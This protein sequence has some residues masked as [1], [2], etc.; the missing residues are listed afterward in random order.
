LTPKV[1]KLVAD[2]NL[3]LECLAL[4]ALPWADLK[5]D[6]IHVLVTRPVQEEIDNHKKDKNRRTFKKAIETNAIFREILKSGGKPYIISESNP[7]VELIL[8]T[9]LEVDTEFEAK[10]KSGK[11]DDIIIGQLYALI[12]VD[13]NADIKLFSDDTGPIHKSMSL[14]LPFMFI[15]EEW[16]KKVQN[17]PEETKVKSLEYDIERLRSQEPK[18]SI[19]A[20]NEAGEIIHDLGYDIIEHTE[21]DESQIETLMSKL[22]TKFPMVESYEGI[23]VEVKKPNALA[24]GIRQTYVPASQ[25]D[26]N[27]Y[28]SEKYPEWLETCRSILTTLHFNLNS[29]MRSP[30]INFKVENIG[31]RPARSAM[32]TFNTTGALEFR[33]VP[34]LEGDSMEDYELPFPS[35]PQPPAA[36]KGKWET[37]MLKGVRDM[38]RVGEAYKAAGLGIDFNR[39]I[40]TPD[41]SRHLFTGKQEDDPNHFYWRPRRPRDFCR[42]ATLKCQQWRHALGPYY[43]D[44]QV[45]CHSEKEKGGGLFTCTVHAENL[46]D[47]MTISIPVKYRVV[48]SDIFEQASI[49]VDKL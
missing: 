15:P 10:L 3:F 41:L 6:V 11:N 30:V 4:K 47:P 46:T 42:K 35:L 5:A 25:N 16:R 9:D 29:P 28:K 33:D 32:I 1:L 23:N 21:L 18:I 26:I 8:L 36:P 19:E 17:S 49:L 40:A 38:M 27:C 44:V 31:T 14:K 12:N 2:T 7:T 39:T 20:L 24:M 34:D 43:F 13:Q 37:A 22:K 45:F 48:K